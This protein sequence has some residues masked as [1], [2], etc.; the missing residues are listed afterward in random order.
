MPKLKDFEGTT[1]V[2]LLPDPTNP[3]AL[4]KVSAPLVSVDD[5]GIW[6]E[7]QQVMNAALD[8]LNLPAVQTRVMQFVPYA[9]IHSIFVPT[10]GTT[11]S[12]KAFGA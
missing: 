5:G 1:I 9:S 8:S 12:E 10:P 2:I 4:M 3:R 7:N 6:I 11:L